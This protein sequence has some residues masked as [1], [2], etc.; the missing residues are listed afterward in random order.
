MDF[1]P[2]VEISEG[3]QSLTI[4]DKILFVALVCLTAAS[5]IAKNAFASGG[6]LVIVELEGQVVYKGDLSDDRKVTVTGERGDVRI[7]VREGKVGVVSADCPNKICVRTGW[8]S[9]DGEVIICLP[10]RVLVKILGEQSD[11]VRGVTG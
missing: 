2:F 10:N 7:Q 4:A 9:L 5:F 8:R 6:S 1:T 3:N 11:T